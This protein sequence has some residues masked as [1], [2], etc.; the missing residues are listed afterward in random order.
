M[1]PLFHVLRRYHRILRLGLPIVF[2]ML[3]QNLLNLVDTAM[4]GQ[5][6]NDA[7]AAVGLATMM[8]WLFAAFAV[9]LGSAVH[10]QVARR[11]GE[12]DQPSAATP[13]N[14]GLVLLLV[15]AIPWSVLAIGF[16][17]PLFAFLASDASWSGDGAGYLTIRLIGLGAVGANFAFR[18]FWTGVDR[19]RVYLFVLMWIHVLNAALNWVFIFGNLGV[20]AMGAEGAALASTVATLAGSVAHF[21]LLHRERGRYGF[22]ELA[23]WDFDFV[24]LL[25]LA[26]PTGFEI[27]L[28][29]LSTAVFFWVAGQ[30]GTAELAATNVLFNIAMVGMLPAM[31]MGM[32]ATT[33]VSQALGA[34]D[35]RLARRWG[36]D[37][38]FVSLALGTVAAIV[39]ALAP[40]SVLSLFVADASTIDLAVGATRWVTLGLVAD[41]LGVSLYYALLG[42]RQNKRAMVVSVVS[43]W[44]LMVPAVLLAGLVFELGLTALWASYVLGYRTMQS[45]AFV[46]LWQ[47]TR[48]AVA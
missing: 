34:G 15:G 1:P 2:G 12:V 19:P 11:V 9:G 17:R 41:M 5:V 24:P 4:L 13:L 16:G 6:G 18:G 38:A 47:R 10:A 28:A 25:R 20:P 30:L 42:A 48:L 8:F 44:T 37:V 33:L 21:R 27:M 26:M 14:Q 43:Q 32:A 40:R 36:W 23:G 29:T 45:L 39:L 31:G 22:L 35:E 7:L 3:S 46:R